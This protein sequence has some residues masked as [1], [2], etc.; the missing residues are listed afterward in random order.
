MQVALD[1]GTIRIGCPE[2]SLSPE[3]RQNVE[4]V[5]CGLKECADIAIDGTNGFEVSLW[6]K[7][8]G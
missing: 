4:S 3:V 5:C 8:G 7:D 6:I 2:L 1:N